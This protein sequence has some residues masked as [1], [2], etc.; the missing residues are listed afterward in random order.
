MLLAYALCC[1]PCVILA[2]ALMFIGA[3][4]LT[5]KVLKAFVIWLRENV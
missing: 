5:W 1:I 4:V 3:I 2:V